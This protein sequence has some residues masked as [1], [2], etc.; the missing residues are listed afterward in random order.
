MTESDVARDIG[1]VL[2]RV[3][4][5]AEVIIERNARPVALIRAVAPPRRT[6]SE[7]IALARAHEAESGQT[8]TMD[9]DFAADVED[10]IRSRKP[11]NP[12]SWD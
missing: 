9:P 11:W 12:P 6:I 1:T 8:P 3:Q 5:G 7:C 2:E 4:S 10:I